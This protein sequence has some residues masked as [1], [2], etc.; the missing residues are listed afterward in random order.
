MTK[1][2]LGLISILVLAIVVFVFIMFHEN[3]AVLS[4]K[5][6]LLC[7][8]Q[9]PLITKQITNSDELTITPHLA[10]Q[11]PPDSKKGKLEILF[12]SQDYYLTVSVQLTETV[13]RVYLALPTHNNVEEIQIIWPEKS[14]SNSRIIDIPANSYLTIRH[15]LQNPALGMDLLPAIERALTYAKN[16]Q[17]KPI[18]LLMLHRLVATY[19]LEGFDN[20]EQQYW[21]F[22]EQAQNPYLRNH[23]KVAARMMDAAQSVSF[24]ELQQV[25]YPDLIIFSALH[26]DRHPLPPETASNWERNIQT[27]GYPATHAVLAYKWAQDNQCTV[28][29]IASDF[30]DRAAQV[31]R[32]EINSSNGFNDL[33]MEILTFLALIDRED[34][35][36]KE[37]VSL[38][39][40]QQLPDGG[41]ALEPGIKESNEHSAGLAAW[42]LLD[43][44]YYNQSFAA[45]IA[46]TQ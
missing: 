1:K 33:E 31:M 4:E 13:S 23:L 2:F 14:I 3:N 43:L 37:W 15:P 7:H 38:L 41:W 21:R 20:I 46:T 5:N 18:S 10:I 9:N 19:K 34:L 26:C 32:N 28:E 24:Q 40:Q 29:N 6:K 44:H 36:K 17:L 30:I 27:G 42:L 22:Y 39:L 35:I 25:G 45:H 11:L 8:N 12:C 16:I